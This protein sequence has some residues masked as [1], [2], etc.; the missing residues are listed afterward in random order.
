METDFLIKGFIIGFS[1]AAPVGP[2]G[3]LC[4][5][6]TLNNG[7]ISGF[8][9]GL[10]A[11]SADAVYGCIAGFG[12]AFISNFLISQQEWLRLAG[13]LFL[14]YL[15]IRTFLSK[16]AKDAASET[17]SHAGSYVETFF[18]TLTNPMTIIYFTAIFA[19]LNL[20][21]SERNY[22]SAGILVLGVFSGSALWWLI[23][24]GGTSIFKSRFGPD[25]PTMK[26][27]NGI[28]GFIIIAF[29]LSALLSLI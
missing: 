7:F 8:I 2:I 26:W 18:L 24:S 17:V 10:G 15:G 19:G 9:T 4:M 6:R 21:G 11:A 1:I 29:G 13:G 22:A 14:I 27:I 5:R 16:P 20:A 28:S 12:L 25:T 23:L 3:I